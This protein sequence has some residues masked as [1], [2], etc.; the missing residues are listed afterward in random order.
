MTARPIT[1]ESTWTDWLAS[2]DLRPF[3]SQVY[4]HAVVVAA[5]P[6]DETLGAS[7]L[8]QHLHDSGTRVELVVATDGEA[9]F[10]A[11]STADRADL[12][13]RRRRELHDALAAQ[14][15][16]EVTVHWL[17]LPDSGLHAHSAELAE[18]LT[19]LLADADV[20][21]V[22]WPSD[23]HPDHATAGEV[24]LR[25]APVT[26][27]RWSYPIWMWHWLR[28]D[29]TTIPAALAFTHRLTPTQRER[30][31]A[32]IT[33]FVS[34]VKPGPNGAEPILAADMV[35]HFEREV[36]VV[37]REPP[38]RSAPITRFAE[39]YERDADP[40]GVA[41]KWYERRKQ[42][43]AMA[44]LPRERYG[45]AVE[46]AC[47]IGQVTQAL[48]QRC[49]RVLAF[50][51]VPSAVR[52]ATEATRNL[53]NV[54]VRPGALPT[55]L[56]TDEPTDLVV[57]SEILYYLDDADLAATVDRAVT[58]LRPGGH[59][60]ALHWL[61]WAPEAP[62]DGDTAHR[63]LLD[64]PALEP[65]VAHRDER[66]VM[67]VL[68]RTGRANDGPVAPATSGPGTSGPAAK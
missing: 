16:A 5:H 3:P 55:D 35:E 11:L 19:P 12:G 59:L 61:P 34:Q 15:M 54:E 53:P 28:P 41:G 60:L 51:P 36:E 43:V 2:P 66:F 37:F 58:A 56:P 47:G 45:F 14:G 20:C 21:L 62:R 65:L 10:P 49:D 44:G 50:D 30:K 48:A 26:T 64:H 68:S 32:G 52:R 57:F 42:A 4:R 23:P 22:P 24:A 1:P 33:T 27:H 25:V 38:R 7:G 18:L 13:R 6:D 31:A 17:G 46:P 67:H 29:D 63:F 39:I 9:A 40:W 8:L